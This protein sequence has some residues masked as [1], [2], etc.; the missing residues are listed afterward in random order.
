MRALL[1]AAVVCVPFLL[2]AVRGGEGVEVAN[3][4]DGNPGPNIRPGRDE[5]AAIRPAWILDPRRRQLSEDYRGPA[6]PFEDPAIVRRLELASSHMERNDFAAALAV[7]DEVLGEATSPI[8]ARRRR[9]RAILLQKEFE[10]SSEEGDGE[11]VGQVLAIE[12]GA[13]LLPRGGGGAAGPAE[14]RV[15]DD[16]ISPTVSVFSRDGIRFLPVVD[17]LREWLLD[18][19]ESARALYVRTYEGPAS[20][21]LDEARSLGGEARIEALARVANRYALTG[22]GQEARR[23][24]AVRLADSGAIARAARELEILLEMGM[25]AGAAVEAATTAQAAYYHLLA[26]EIDAAE[27]ALS[28]VA[29]RHSEAAVRVRGVAT[30]GN[31]LPS[32]ELFTELRATAEAIARPPSPWPAPQGSYDRIFPAL[33]TETPPRAGAELRWY[34]PLHDL[35]VE[36]EQRTAS[37]PENTG[38]VQ[39]VRAG[40]LLLVRRPGEIRAIRSE[41]GELVW[42]SAFDPPDITGRQYSSVSPLATVGLE[43]TVFRPSGVDPGSD[44]AHVAFVDHAPMI[45]FDQ[46]K[47][48]Q[49]TPN[50]LVGID[51]ATGKL[52]W[53]LSGDTGDRRTALTGMSFTGA[54]VPAGGVLVAPAYRQGGLYLVGIDAGPSGATLLW[55]TRLY[56]F[57]INYYRQH[58]FNTTGG[59]QVS[60]RDG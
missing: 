44:T 46:K 2:G 3:R 19:P 51:A 4:P 34:H 36:G 35:P 32:H 13:M 23:E 53:R 59:T 17:A 14:A 30:L 49:Y 54:P 37:R 41:N 8:E 38:P 18:L 45:T 58:S 31:D 52:V 56:S 40:D 60:S 43:L 55:M 25:N 47:G 24:L 1:G 6:V 15:S 42:E 29:T 26:G 9:D 12:D 33:A 5:G 7:I 50:T 11:A 27:R 16:P 21:G 57:D 39:V 22:P 28:R 20:R 48:F 10:E